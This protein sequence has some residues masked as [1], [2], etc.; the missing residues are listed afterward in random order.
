MDTFT[1]ITERTVTKEFD[2]QSLPKII[3]ENIIEMAMNAP[4]AKNR[5]PW[6]FVVVREKKLNE[7]IEY[8]SELGL[9][10]DVDFSTIRKASAVILVFNRYK[11]TEN[12]YSKITEEM[13]LVSIGSAVQNLV[14]A[15]ENFNLGTI[16]VGDFAKYEKEIGKW[17][18]IEEAE[19]SYLVTGLVLGFPVKNGVKKDHLEVEELTEWLE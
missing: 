11:L 12:N 15:A 13:D 14:L 17:L 18:G 4:S 10:F 6:K 9:K 1:A 2:D 3:I 5:Q 7:L 8:V 16:L 19:E